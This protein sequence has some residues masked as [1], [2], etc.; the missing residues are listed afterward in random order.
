[1]FQIHKEGWNFGFIGCLC[2]VSFSWCLHSFSYIVRSQFVEFDKICC[3]GRNRS[4]HLKIPFFVNR[5]NNSGFWICVDFSVS[6]SIIASVLTIIIKIRL[7]QMTKSYTT[8]L[9]EVKT[10][11]LPSIPRVSLFTWMKLLKK[12]LRCF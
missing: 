6:T 10:R 12:I 11:L 1:M 5:I 9:K 3:L 8:V 2:L 4:F 7:L